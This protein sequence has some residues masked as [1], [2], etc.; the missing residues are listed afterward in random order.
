MKSLTII[1]AAVALSPSTVLAI[2]CNADN[3]LRALR[4]N[5]AKASPFCSTYTLPPPN[6]PLP[7]YVSA[8]PASRV[9]SACSCFITTISTTLKTSTTSKSSTLSSSTSKSTTTSSTTSSTTTTTSD[10]PTP[11]PYYC[12]GDAITNGDFHLGPNGKP[13]PWVFTPATSGGGQSTSTSYSEGSAVLSVNNG[14]TGG[15]GGTYIAQSIPGLCYGVLFNLTYTSQLNIYG[16]Q[17]YRA[18]SVYYSLDSIGQLVHIGPPSGDIPPFQM[19]T[20]S[21]Q[22]EYYGNGRPDTL[23]IS[24]SCNAPGGSYVIDDVHLIGYNHE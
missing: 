19:E 2:V 4:G 17:P 14:Q 8:Y 5:S 16:G 18:C 3:V 12:E 1:T 15:Y 11:T 13:D 24:L 7:T 23:T 6:Q 10:E 22:F 21:Y 20:R 9:S